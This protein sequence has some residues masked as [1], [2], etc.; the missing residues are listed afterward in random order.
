MNSLCI[1]M[2]ILCHSFEVISFAVPRSTI[3]LQFIPIWQLDFVVNVNLVPFLVVVILELECW[4]E[5]GS[6]YAGCLQHDLSS[7]FILFSF[8]V[9]ISSFAFGYNATW[10]ADRQK[11]TSWIN[12]WLGELRMISWFTMFAS[13]QW[14][15]PII[16]VEYQ[17]LSVR[18][19]ITVSPG[20]IVSGDIWQGRGQSM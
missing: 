11:K 1:I 12:G 13:K 18:E 6:R 3:V 10:P 4:F 7:K 8:P 16:N 14:N 5:K 20:C 15:D 9:T 19:R 17:C 2:Y